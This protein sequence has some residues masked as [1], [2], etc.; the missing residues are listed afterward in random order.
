MRRKLRVN[1]KAFLPDSEPANYQLQP[2]LDPK[3]P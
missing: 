3:D 1:P 2:G